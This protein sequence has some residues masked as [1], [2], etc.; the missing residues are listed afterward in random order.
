[1][2]SKEEFAKEYNE[3]MKV[4][5]GNLGKF[6]GQVMLMPIFLFI[7]LCTITEYSS[8]LYIKV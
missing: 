8:L 3:F 2:I 4:M 5:A 1:M 7:I 6:R